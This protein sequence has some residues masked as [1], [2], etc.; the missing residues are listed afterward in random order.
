MAWHAAWRAT[1]AVPL[2]RRPQLGYMHL[3]TGGGGL[4]WRQPPVLEGLQWEGVGSVWG[5]ERRCRYLHAF[6]AT[7][8]MQEVVG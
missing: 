3:Q 4:D 2:H 5:A 8:G 7:V 1:A 6:I